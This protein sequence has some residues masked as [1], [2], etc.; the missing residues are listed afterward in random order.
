MT[1]EEG[2]NSAERT[3]RGASF[4]NSLPPNHRGPGS[5][6]SNR[7]QTRIPGEPGQVARDA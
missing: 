4:V 2:L 7:R 3:R 1:A 6:P 5:R